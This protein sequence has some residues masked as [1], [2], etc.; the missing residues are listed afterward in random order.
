MCLNT[1]P[2]RAPIPNPIITTYGYIARVWTLLARHKMPTRL[3]NN[4]AVFPRTFVLIDSSLGRLGDYRMGMRSPASPMILQ[5]V[6]RSFF[7]A[8]NVMPFW[9]LGD[10]S[11]CSRV[12]RGQGLHSS[13]SFLP[14]A[15]AHC[16]GLKAPAS[17]HWLWLQLAR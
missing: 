16:R 2:P 9:K 3:P 8:L 4:I 5:D 15:I 7:S 6:S 13:T 10:C 12:S 1:P 11:I 17:A 14:P